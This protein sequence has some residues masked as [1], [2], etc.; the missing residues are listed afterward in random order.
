ML[1][2]DA[3][4]WPW[5]ERYLELELKGGEIPFAGEGFAEGGIFR[6]RFRVI[7]QQMAPKWG[8]YSRK[9]E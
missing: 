8:R 9:R 2:L 5:D 1:T 3:S 6:L 4:S 7:V